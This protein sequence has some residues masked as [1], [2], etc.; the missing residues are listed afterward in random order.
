MNIWCNLDPL[1]HLVISVLKETQADTDTEWHNN[2]INKQRS[3]KIGGKKDLDRL[4]LTIQ[5]YNYYKN[6]QN[7]LQYLKTICCHNSG[8]KQF[9]CLYWAMANE[10]L[11]L[12]FLRT[13]VIVLMLWTFNECVQYYFYNLNIVDYRNTVEIW[14]QCYYKSIITYHHLCL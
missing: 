1:I 3:R 2:F 14:H 7:L 9:K 11:I 10:R 4:K 5:S 6:H 8:E 13:Y 12:T